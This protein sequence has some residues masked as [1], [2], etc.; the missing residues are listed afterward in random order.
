MINERIKGTVIIMNAI[1]S[2]ELK[3]NTIPISQN[4]IRRDNLKKI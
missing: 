2:V 4:E 3:R 1:I